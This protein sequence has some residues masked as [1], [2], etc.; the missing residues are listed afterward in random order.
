MA[1]PPE[2]QDIDRPL[3]HCK[4][5]DRVTIT[6]LDSPYV[7]SMATRLGLVEGCTVTCQAVVPS[8]PVVVRR[9]GM[10]LA[11]GRAYA[12]EIMV[13]KTHSAMEALV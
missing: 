10:E 13:K 8:G 6:R 5:G 12:A 4:P 9:G 7:A 11:I 1:L 2:Q 3:S